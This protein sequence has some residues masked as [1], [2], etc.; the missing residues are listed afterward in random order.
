MLSS[1]AIEGKLNIRADVSK[2]R[3]WYKKIVQGFNDTLDAVIVPLNVAAEYV[4]QISKGEIPQKITDDYKGDFDEI[5]N[6]LNNCI[7]GLQ[8]LVECSNV[9]QRMYLND[10]TN[11]VEGNYFGIYATMGESINGLRERLLSIKSL[12]PT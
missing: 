10:H 3:G 7:D 1:A 5:K 4:D 2:H 8:C 6:N 12:I 11:G 9:L